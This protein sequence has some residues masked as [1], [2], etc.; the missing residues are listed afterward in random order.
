MTSRPW[1]FRTAATAVALATAAAT[2]S[3]YAVAQADEGAPA[4]VERHD[5]ADNTH[6]EHNLDGPLS[7]TQEAQ[8]EEALKQ[9]ISGDAQV[10]KREG[11]QVV[12]L[13]SK[14]GDSKYVELGREK[15]DK[16]F[17]ILVEFGDKISEFGGTAGPP[18]TR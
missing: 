10:Q 1:T 3:T 5:P 7:K 4:S 14:K 8:R 9:V 2:F 16:I 17:T 12:Q 11:S 13:K 15:T 18:T 6:A